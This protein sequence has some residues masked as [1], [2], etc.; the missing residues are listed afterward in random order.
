MN[1]SSLL[2]LY[3][4]AA[5]CSILPSPTA[6]LEAERDLI[7]WSERQRNDRAV[8]SNNRG[9]ILQ[10][11]QQ[12]QQQQNQ[13]QQGY[14]PRNTTQKRGLEVLSWTPRIFL[15]RGFL[16]EAEC[17]YLIHLASPR[18]ARSG[19]V[20]EGGGDGISDI[21]TSNGMFF[22]RAENKDIEEIERRLSEWTLIPPGNGEGFQV[23]RYEKDQE[24][25]GHFDYFFDEV[26]VRNGG[27]RLATVLMYLESPES[28]G[29]TVFAN[30]PK[31]ATQTLEAGFSECAMDGL[32]VKPEKGDAVLFWSL[33]TAGTLD[34]GSLHGSCPVISGIKYAATK[35]YHVGHYAQG[36]NERGEKVQH[37]VFVPPPP[38]APVW[39]KNKKHECQG[40]AESGECEN[41]REYMVGTKEHPGDC[42]L[43]CGRCDL[44]SEADRRV[45]LDLGRKD[46]SK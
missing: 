8:I 45:G 21:R 7:G 1:P 34:K 5:S 9:G 6:A 38:P 40:W 17:N 46:L 10:Q 15:Y 32:A 37:V 4:L 23:L 43:A 35:W 28:G 30:V 12:Q 39:C 33:T 16:S 11:Q 19:V 18:L 26:S 42:L 31:P 36:P 20:E 25:K 29:E 14:A 24:Y 22:D 27:N 3:F 2:S 13:Q 41:N 44:T